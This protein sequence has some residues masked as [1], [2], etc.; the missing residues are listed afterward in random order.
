MES[1]QITNPRPF[2]FERI[3][4]VNY[5]TEDFLEGLYWLLHESHL[6]QV[7]IWIPKTQLCHINMGTT[8]R[9]K[10]GK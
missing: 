10:K 3:P 2:H 4:L 6:P 9:K 5:K 1:A 8:M 7:R